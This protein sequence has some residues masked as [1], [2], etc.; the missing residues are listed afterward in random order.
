MTANRR[1][2]ALGKKIKKTIA[3]GVLGSILAPGIGTAVGAAIGHGMD[4]KDDGKKDSKKGPQ[5]SGASDNVGA[6]DMQETVGDDGSTESYQR[7]R[8]R[9][10]GTKVSEGADTFSGGTLGG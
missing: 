4:R 9:A 8:R 5:S 10:A 2:T 1:R 6:A 7:S 3:G